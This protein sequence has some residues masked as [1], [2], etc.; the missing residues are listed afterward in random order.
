MKMYKSNSNFQH[1][2]KRVKIRI[3]FEIETIEPSNFSK[4]DIEFRYNQ[5]SWCAD[6]AIDMILQQQK[7]DSCL[8]KSC[9]VEY[10][11]TIQ[12]NKNILSG[13]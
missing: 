12:E 7:K 5:G 8:C 11:E 10:V 13:G 3:S 4:E 1:A 6:N 2:Q 9:K